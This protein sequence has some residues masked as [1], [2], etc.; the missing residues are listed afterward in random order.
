MENLRFLLLTWD[1]VQSLSETVVDKI[2]KDCFNPDIIIA[3][4]RGGFDPARIISDQLGVRKL[5]SLQITYYMGVNRTSDQP[6]I[7]HPLNAKVSGLKALVVDDVADSGESLKAV[8]GYVGSFNPVEIK[9]ATLHYKPWSVYEPDYYAEEVDKWIIYPWE[10]RETLLNIRETLFKK[11]VEEEKLKD[12][13]S[14][15]GFSRKQ[16]KRYLDSNF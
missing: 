13:L 15:I 8:K 14:E 10:T 11:G 3:V 6:R 12:I 7:I 16:I 1:D 2:K 9:T 5:A 4:S